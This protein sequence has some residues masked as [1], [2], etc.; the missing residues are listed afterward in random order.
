MM[1]SEFEAVAKYNPS[2]FRNPN[3]PVEKIS[4]DNAKAFCEK[5]TEYERRAGKLPARLQI[6]AADGVAVVDV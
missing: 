2:F 3:R 5:L 1:Q 4:W 6:L